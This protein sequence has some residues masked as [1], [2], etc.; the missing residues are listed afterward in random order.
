MILERKSLTKRVVRFGRK[1]L[2]KR[3]VG[4]GRKS[5]TKSM[6]RFRRKSLKII[7]RSSHW[8]ITDSKYS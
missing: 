5:L 3:M 1:S 2:T 7:V 4:F 8:L 6:V